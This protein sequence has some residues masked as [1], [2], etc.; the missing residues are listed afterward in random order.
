MKTSI[1][2]QVSNIVLRNK[3]YYHWQEFFDILNEGPDKVKEELLNMWNDTKQKLSADQSIEIVDLNK[4]VTEKDFDITLNMTKNKVKV[5][6]IAFPDSDEAMAQSKCIALALT[7]KMPRYL[8]M[9]YFSKEGNEES[10]MVGEWVLKDTNFVH[11]NYGKLAS[12]TIGN[13]AYRVQEE[14]EKM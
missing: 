11:Q 9:E 10:F 12:P 1:S 4:E 3:I 13:F 14:I 7:D 6:Y 5:F 2:Y 8:T